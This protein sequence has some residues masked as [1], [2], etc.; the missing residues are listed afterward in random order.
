MQINVQPGS[1]V[2]AGVQKIGFDGFKMGVIPAGI[3]EPRIGYD[4]DPATH[5]GLTLHSNKFTVP[6][7]PTDIG[8]D[9]ATT[10]VVFATNSPR[11]TAIPEGATFVGLEIRKQFAAYATDITGTQGILAMHVAGLVLDGTVYRMLTPL[12]CYLLK[13]CAARYDNP[14]D[15]NFFYTTIVLPGDTERYYGVYQHSGFRIPPGITHVGAIFSVPSGGTVFTDATGYD[16]LT[17]FW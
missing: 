15:K 13:E 7:S 1:A 4:V 8:V 10:G 14:T 2:A 16:V 3:H 17:H 9:I 12:G 11:V 6:N 5:K